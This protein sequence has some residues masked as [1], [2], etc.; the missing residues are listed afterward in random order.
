MGYWD[1]VVWEAK[2]TVGVLGNSVGIGMFVSE[3]EKMCPNDWT[4]KGLNRRR[5]PGETVPLLSSGVGTGKQTHAD[6]NKAGPLGPSGP[7]A[8]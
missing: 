1:V 4:G 5:H 8:L 6:R 3:D 7:A 2:C